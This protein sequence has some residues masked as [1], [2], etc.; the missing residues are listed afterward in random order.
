V[1]IGCR[2]RDNKSNIKKRR[3]VVLETGRCGEG[4]G[5]RPQSSLRP[6]WPVSGPADSSGSAASKSSEI[7]AIVLDERKAEKAKSFVVV[8]VALMAEHTDRRTTSAST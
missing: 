6:V 1:L 7:S 5:A 4:D 3:D 2:I 8:C